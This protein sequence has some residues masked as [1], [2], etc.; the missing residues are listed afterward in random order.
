MNKRAALWVAL[1][2]IVALAGGCSAAR[3]NT[4]MGN[5]VNLSYA[6]AQRDGSHQ[7]C[8]R[9]RV[10]GEESEIASLL[11]L[12]HGLQAPADSGQG[13]L[14]KTVGGGQVVGG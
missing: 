7:M 4:L 2:M 11:S 5:R 3:Q 12:D 8:I 1:V 14:T 9:E 6:G 13:R 10:G